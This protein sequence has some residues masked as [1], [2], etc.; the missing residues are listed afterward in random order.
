[1]KR[2][3]FVPFCPGPHHL[4]GG[5]CAASLFISSG[6]QQGL[7]VVSEQCVSADR[8]FWMPGAALLDF[9]GTETAAALGTHRNVNTLRKS[10]VALLPASCWCEPVLLWWGWAWEVG[11]SAGKGHVS[12]ACLDSLCFQIQ[13]WR[14]PHLLCQG[15]LCTP[16][17][18]LWPFVSCGEPP[19]P[20][21]SAVQRRSWRRDEGQS[22]AGRGPA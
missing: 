21:P 6:E 3:C 11:V 5:W 2:P 12:H 8:C 20:I 14:T 4:I 9:P 7:A 22:L 18:C 15:D 16:Q 13:N 10:D 1:M 17:S 19:H